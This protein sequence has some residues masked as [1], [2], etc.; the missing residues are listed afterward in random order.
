MILPNNKKVIVL[1]PVPVYRM[2]FEGNCHR[3][4]IETGTLWMYCMNEGD[5]TREGY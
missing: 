3:S 4:H 1:L 5:N 2:W